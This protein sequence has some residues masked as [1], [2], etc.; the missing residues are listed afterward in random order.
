MS[1]LHCDTLAAKRAKQCFSFPSYLKHSQIN[2][3]DTKR[4]AW[5]QRTPTLFFLHSVFFGREYREVSNAKFSLR[6]KFNRKRWVR[7]ALRWSVQQ[8]LHRGIKIYRLVPKKNVDL[9]I[10][11]RKKTRINVALFWLQ[12][13]HLFASLELQFL[14]LLNSL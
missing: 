11:N 4:S 10:S 1:P 14:F 13:T 5:I 8:S 12:N 7:V 3:I 2:I 9:N 6:S